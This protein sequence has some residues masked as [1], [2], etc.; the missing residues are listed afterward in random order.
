MVEEKCQFVIRLLK[1]DLANL[2]VALPG[3]PLGE[4]Q[5]EEMI[6]DLLE[7]T[8]SRLRVK[9]KGQGSAELMKEITSIGSD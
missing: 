9:L 2:P 4:T 1:S 3:S 7:Q 6:R 5:S 8:L